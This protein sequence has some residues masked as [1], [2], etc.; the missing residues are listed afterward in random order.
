MKIYVAGKI[1]G[2]KEYKE[3]FKKVAEKLES[4]GHSVMNPSILP[5]GFE[6]GEYMIICYSMIDVCEVVY[7]LDNWKDSK[8]AKMEHDYAIRNNKQIMFQEVGA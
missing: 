5:P 2:L 1:T 8:G 7:F 3:N 6:H 4:E